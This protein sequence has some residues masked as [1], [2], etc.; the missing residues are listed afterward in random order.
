VNIPQITLGQPV[1]TSAALHLGEKVFRGFIIQIGGI[2]FLDLGRILK[3]IF[4]GSG[5]GPR[6]ENRPAKAVYRQHRQSAGMVDMGVGENHIGKNL[7]V[8]RQHPVFRFRLP[9]PALEKPAIKKDGV[10]GVVRV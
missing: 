10:T 7:R 5:G 3:K 4:T 9:P 8:D 1:F 6:A 2:A